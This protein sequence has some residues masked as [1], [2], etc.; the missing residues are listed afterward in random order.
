MPLY[1]NGAPIGRLFPAGSFS[2]SQGFVPGVLTAGGGQLLIGTGM[3]ALMGQSNMVSAGANAQGGGGGGAGIGTP[4]SADGG[5]NISLTTPFTGCLM[6]E[7]YATAPT[8]P[9]NYF[10]TTLEFLLPYSGSGGANMG[11]EQTLGRW[12]VNYGVFPNPALIKFAVSSTRLDVHW[13]SQFPSGTATT[14]YQ[15]AIAYLKAARSS[16]N[17][18][19]DG[20]IWVQGESDAGTSSAANAYQ[21]NLAT[22]IARVRADLGVPNL[23]FILT[24]MNAASAFGAFRDTVRAAQAAF[25]ASDPNSI[26]VNIDDIFLESDPHYAMIGQADHGDRIAVGVRNLLGKTSNNL[27]SGSFPYYQYASAG[28]STFSGGIAHPRSGADPIF[29]DREFL[30]AV[31][32]ANTGTVAAL[33]AV[34][35]SNGTTGSVGFTQVGSQVIS[36][37]ATT[38]QKTLTVWER[39]LGPTTPTGSNGRFGS[40]AVQ[41]LSGTSALN[42]ARIFS[43]RNG[44][45]APTTTFV[46]A[47]NN[48]N[49]ATLVFPS[50]TSSVANSMVMGFVT[51]A[52]VNNHM[53]SVTNATMTNVSIKWDSI[54]NPGAGV[55]HLGMFTAQLPTAGAYGPT[56]VT[57]SGSGNNAGFMALVAPS[58]S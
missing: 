16:L 12:L 1:P 31:T 4:R 50:I 30:A 42:V 58:G 10:D 11:P 25:V 23:P 22:F 39:I 41:M 21:A 55:M 57:M 33:S 17:R 8:T 13:L 45:S 24:Q 27:G 43:V 3:F 56:T 5:Y 38:N 26:L 28:C 35:G 14:M 2:L 52:G 20:L 51:T 40:P 49:N 46:T 7:K 9:M 32:Y 29:N 19:Y 48:A 18:Q 47:A 15:D 54:Y 6:S 44:N 36:T 37:F 53:L 34:T